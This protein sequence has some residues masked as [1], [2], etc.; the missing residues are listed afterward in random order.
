MP[1]RPELPELLGLLRLLPLEPLAAS[2][3]R[4]S[5]AAALKPVILPGEVFTLKIVREG[6]DK[7]QGVG[8]LSDGTLVVVNNAQKFIGHSIE[9]QVMSLLQSAT[10]T[11]A[12][13]DAKVTPGTA[14]VHAP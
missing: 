2:S 8:Y 6:K 10:G 13:A 14:N 9:V 1:P 7:G 12:F 4:P 3:E 11:M 5:P